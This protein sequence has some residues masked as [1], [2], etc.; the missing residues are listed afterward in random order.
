[1]VVISYKEG[2][3][4]SG[5]YV[6]TVKIPVEVKGLGIDDGLV[7]G[8]KWF[9]ENFKYTGEGTPIVEFEVQTEMD[10]DTQ[11]ERIK[12]RRELL[13]KLIAE[14][15]DGWARATYETWES[16]RD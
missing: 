3:E 10:Y 7:E 15:P 16:E 2:E 8:K 4:M 5:W 11:D 6:V 12:D 1:M 9:N 14:D 13:A